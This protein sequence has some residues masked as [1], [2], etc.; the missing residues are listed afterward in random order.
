[1]GVGVGV[2]SAANPVGAETVRRRFPSLCC[3]GAKTDKKR[4]MA[5][6]DFQ[7]KEE[8]PCKPSLRRRFALFMVALIDPAANTARVIV[9]CP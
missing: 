6:S 8:Q 3:C 7:T 9:K 4:R 5:G 1:M 2:V